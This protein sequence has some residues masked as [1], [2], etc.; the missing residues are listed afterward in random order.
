M[1]CFRKRLLKLSGEVRWRLMRDP[2]ENMD[3][4]LLNVMQIDEVSGTQQPT[5]NDR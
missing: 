4:D 1:R 5:G 3:I 2:R